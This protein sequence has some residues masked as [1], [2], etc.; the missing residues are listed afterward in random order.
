MQRSSV[1]MQGSKLAFPSPMSQLCVPP[2]PYLEIRSTDM[3][4]DGVLVKQCQPTCILKF[5]FSS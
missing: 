3:V 1:S 5:Y 2:F 4:A